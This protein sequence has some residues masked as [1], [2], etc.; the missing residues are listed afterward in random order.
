MLTY[1]I[2]IVIGITV[3]AFLTGDVK[4]S[5]T[6]ECFQ[7]TTRCCRALKRPANAPDGRSACR[8]ALIEWLRR[9]PVSDPLIPLELA[10]RLA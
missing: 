8:E 1:R 9:L 5:P 3:N 7:Q 2:L 10:R 6:A 4:T